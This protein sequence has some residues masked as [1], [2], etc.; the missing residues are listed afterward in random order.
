LDASKR[1]TPDFG[2]VELITKELMGE[3]W[4]PYDVLEDN[5]ER[6]NFEDTLMRLFVERV[7]LDMEELFL[8]G[9]TDNT[10]DDLLSV[11]DGILTLVSPSK[12]IDCSAYTNVDK[13]L[14]KAG[15][16]NM[17]TKYLRARNLLRFFTSHHAETE[18]R[19]SLADRSTALGDE[20]TTGFTPT[21]SFGVPVIPAALM[22]ENKV[23]LTDPQN[24]ILGVQRQIMIE[25]D[26]DIRR[27]VL[28]VV[29]T[30]RVD[31]QIERSD[32]CVVM[33]NFTDSGLPTTSTTTTTTTAP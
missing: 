18:Y 17:S 4:I 12:V 13:S 3:Y 16:Q 8:L 9:D 22:P 23:L 31:I 32:A 7:G 19:D 29:C 6:G 14:F 24:L 28:V 10:G 33:E 26:R 5:I 15:I 11:T 1:A 2:I 25:T 21:K 20:K 30:M 27:R